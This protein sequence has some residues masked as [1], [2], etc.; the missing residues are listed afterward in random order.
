MPT[1]DAHRDRF[2]Q[3]SDEALRTLLASEESDDLTSADFRA[4]TEELVRRGLRK[5]TAPSR[6]VE[7][8]GTP[9]C[10]H[11]KASLSRRFIAAAIDSAIVIAGFVLIWPII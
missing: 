1:H 2:G 6:P 7:N 11:Q 5:S 10:S 9:G 3:L 8:L 4:L